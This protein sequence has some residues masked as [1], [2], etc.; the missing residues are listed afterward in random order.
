MK[1]SAWDRDAEDYN[2]K[3]Q[4]EVFYVVMNGKEKALSKADLLKQ[5]KINL[6][7]RSQE[8]PE[9]EL[10]LPEPQSSARSQARHAVPASALCSRRRSA[11]P[12][13]KAKSTS[14]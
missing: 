11:S 12:R 4:S 10:L 8:P 7:E 5:I 13:S 6:P 1:I 3:T 2:G 14:A 9:R